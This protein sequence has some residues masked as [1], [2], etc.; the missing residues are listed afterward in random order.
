MEITEK[1][2]TY[3][4]VSNLSKKRLVFQE[5]IIVAD[6]NTVDIA[7][8][9]IKKES[10]NLLSIYAPIPSNTEDGYLV[11]ELLNRYYNQFF[12]QQK[13]DFLKQ[14][15]ALG[16]EKYPINTEI[17]KDIDE[18]NTASFQYFGSKDIIGEKTIELKKMSNPI[19]NAILNTH[20][21]ELSSRHK[22]ANKIM[23]MPITNRISCSE[24]QTHLIVNFNK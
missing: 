10:E 18:I 6:K 9:S 20:I 11:C 8:N 21:E 4:L 19:A 24:S 16:R 12:D 14:N 5:A 15:I 3:D 2:I 17:K 13:L 23:N 1:N 7:S 22:M